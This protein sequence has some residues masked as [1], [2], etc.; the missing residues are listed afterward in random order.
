MVTGIFAGDVEELSLAA[1]FPRLAAL[2]AR[3]GLLRGQVID[4]IERRGSPR[5]KRR[6]YAPVGGMERVIDALATDLG[7][8]LKLGARVEAVRTA[9]SRVRVALGGGG[10][11][12]TFDAAVLA[13][14]APQAAVVVG[15]AAPALAAL[16]GEFRYVPV[17]AVHLGYRREEIAH[18]LDGFG[19]L[20]APGEALRILGAVF[21]SAIFSDRAPAGCALFRCMLGGAR[22]PRVLELDDSA[23][24]E[25]ARRDLEPLIGARGGPIQTAVTRWPQAIAQ[26]TRG[27]SERVYR[28][29]E[30]A[31]QSGLVLAGAAFRGVAVNDCVASAVAVAEQVGRVLAAAAS[32]GSA[33]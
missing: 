28:A 25:S 7:P 10:R 32:R 26:Y 6:M 8:A 23:L 17:A 33:A 20:V 11:E 30:L 31:A 12:E 16:L 19:F 15:D 18:A 24:I 14:P 1:A 27:H 3:G 13:L 5:G 22:D 29:S 9:G 4:M 21:E 2:E